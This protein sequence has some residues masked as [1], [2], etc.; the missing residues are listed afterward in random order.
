[1]NAR[2]G[3]VVVGGSAG[4]VEAA[5]S[6]VAGL[7]ADL[8]A[9]V[10]LTLHIGRGAR[11]NLPRILTRSGRLAAE[12]VVDGRPL[13]P[14]RIMV[15]PPDRHLLVVDG[16]VRLSAGPTINRQRPAVD[17]MFASAARWAGPGVVAVVLSGTL[18]DGAVGAALVAR[19]GGRVIVQDPAEAAFSSMPRAARAA[20][21][22]ALTLPVRAIGPTAAELLGDV[23]RSLHPAKELDITAS[24]PEHDDVAF[25]SPDE[26]RLT[27]LA[28]PECGGSLA[29]I[30]LDT[31]FYFRCHVGHQYSPQT[32][33]A[34][35]RVNAEAK[36][37]S[38]TAALEEH[39][40]LARHLAARPSSEQE[41]SGEYRHA[42]DESTR[43]AQMLTSHLR[44]RQPLEVDQDGV[45]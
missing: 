12:H 6:L 22:D 30:D 1:M 26:S 5:I 4:G 8:P 40:V 41:Q 2:G 15:A 3:V 43:T 35:Q 24:M 45:V 29:E 14:G 13:Q 44:D 16:R 31:V 25:L 36:L 37:W 38:A 23:R 10:L 7:P 34:A 42:A 28:C 27:R 21:P 9:S 11:S 32:L 39:A 19:A 20:V 18:D 33:E 17:P